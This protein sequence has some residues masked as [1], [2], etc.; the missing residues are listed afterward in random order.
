MVVLIIQ[1]IEQSRQF[2]NSLLANLI[3]AKMGLEIEMS[4]KPA[5]YTLFVTIEHDPKKDTN[6]I[7]FCHGK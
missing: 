1:L 7:D 6:E 2:V 4:A 3:K 5:E